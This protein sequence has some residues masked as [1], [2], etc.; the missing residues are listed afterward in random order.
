MTRRDADR[1]EAGVDWVVSS[2][3]ESIGDVPPKFVLQFDCGGRGK[4][5]MREEDKLRVLAKLQSGISSTAP[6][7]G[8]YS[9]G[10]IGP[11]NQ[12]NSFHNYTVVLVAFY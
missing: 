4:Q 10:E 8:F 2:V 7:I 12:V 9:F 6:W 3:R 1:V 11:V 5:L